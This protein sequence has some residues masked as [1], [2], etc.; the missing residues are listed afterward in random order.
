[1]GRSRRAGLV[2]LPTDIVDGP[3]AGCDPRQM[4]LRFCSKE[5]WKLSKVDMGMV[6]SVAMGMMR[7]TTNGAPVGCGGFMPNR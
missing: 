4:G 5:E 3:W 2:A 7:P 6:R 1:M